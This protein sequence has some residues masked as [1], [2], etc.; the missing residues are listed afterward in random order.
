MEEPLS[1]IL[2][3]WGEVNNLPETT[4]EEIDAKQ[5][6]YNQLISGSKWWKLK[7][8]ADMQVA[9]FFIPKTT[10][11]KDRLITDAT[12]REYL[13]G[14]KTMTDQP[15]AWQPPKHNKKGFFI[16]FLNSLKCL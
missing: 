11:N 12:Y 5:A 2:E 16:G 6:K 8:L 15:T 1:G 7:T 4:P 3:K 14:Q 10:A 9:Q 13:N